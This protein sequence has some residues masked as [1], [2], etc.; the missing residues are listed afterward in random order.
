M[1]AGMGSSA[2]RRDTAERKKRGDK[3]VAPLPYIRYPLDFHT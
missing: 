2:D 1:K 3:N